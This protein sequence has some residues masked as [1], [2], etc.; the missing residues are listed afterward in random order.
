MHFY[1]FNIG[2]FALHTSHLTLE[3]EGVYRR[4]LDFYYDTELPI[5]IKTQTV[6][7][8]LRLGS[9]GET[10]AL[11]LEEF[12]IKQDDGWHNLRADIE[13]A[14]YHS[15]AETARANGKKGGRPKKNSGPKT[16]SV[17]LANPDLTQT[18]AK[19]E[20]VT[21]KQELVTNV[22]SPA[23]AGKRKTSLSPDFIL[24]KHKAGLAMKYWS[25]KGRTDL[26]VREIFEQFT[27][28]CKANGKT[29]L[30]WDSAWQTWYVNAVK[31]ERGNQNGTSKQAFGQRGKALSKSE[32]RDEDARIYLEKNNGNGVAGAPS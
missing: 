3:E 28:Y 25:G 29:Y 1:P 19:Q 21:K 26:D 2:D 12:F 8:R 14:D 15:K 23:K 18:K 11:V 17:I 24:T 7:R 27:T 31:F 4:L 5:P 9:Y 16:Q 22:S 13:I 30:D 10:V 6:I 32:R 20:L